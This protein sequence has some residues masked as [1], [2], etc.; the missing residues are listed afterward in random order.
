MHYLL[1]AQAASQDRLE[2]IR[3]RHQDSQSNQLKDRDLKCELGKIKNTQQDSTFPKGST[4]VDVKK[5]K[6]LYLEEVKTGR[7]L[8][9]ELERQVHIFWNGNESDSSFLMHL[10]SKSLFCTCTAS[11]VEHE[12]VYLW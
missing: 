2:H 8:A 3:A 9:K 12:M 5:Y 6:E 7:C 11:C 10:P 1:Q 4:R